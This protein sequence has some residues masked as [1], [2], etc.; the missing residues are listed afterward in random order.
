LIDSIL[1]HG[2]VS[3]IES[4]C[5]YMEILFCSSHIFQPLVVGMLEG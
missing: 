5:L 2:P 1:L 3:F 4:Y